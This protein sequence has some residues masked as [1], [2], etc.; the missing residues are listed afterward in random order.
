[1]AYT[2]YEKTKW[3]DTESPEYTADSPSVCADNL[4]KMEQGIY[5]SVRRSGDKME[6]ALELYRSPQSD[7]EAAN[8]GY[9]DSNILL[10]ETDYYIEEGKY[11]VVL[12]KIPNYNSKNYLVLV[13]TTVYSFST[14]DIEDQYIFPPYWTPV[15]DT[16]EH[17]SSCLSPFY[18][19]GYNGVY[20]YVNKDGVIR[21]QRNDG[22][23]SKSGS[24]RLLLIPH[25]Q[26]S[27]IPV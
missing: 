9:V 4:N 17:G 11:E 2:K 5:E 6:G 3:V 7:M 10:I 25:G 16:Y 8:K 24:I 19:N 20:I 13:K 27:L 12:G 23:R 14:P 18:D 15:L 21:L 22:R 1:M 26:T